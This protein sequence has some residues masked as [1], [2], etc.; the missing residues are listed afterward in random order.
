MFLPKPPLKDL[1]NV[2]SSKM[3]FH[4]VLLLIRKLNLGPEKHDNGPTIMESNGLTIFPS[5]LKKV[6]LVEIWNG[7]WSSEDIIE[8]SIRWQH[9]ESWGKVLQNA[10]YAL[11]QHPI[12]GMVSPIAR[13]HESRNQKA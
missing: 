12:Y 1:Q 11:N 13:L 9:L 3:A 2:L 4:A 5:I 10:V 6:A 8:G 7:L